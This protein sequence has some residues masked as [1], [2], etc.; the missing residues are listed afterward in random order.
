M[1]C[2]ETLKQQKCFLGSK[3]FSV[4]CVLGC[5][6]IWG[7]H[8][9]WQH[10][11]MLSVDWQIFLTSFFAALTFKIVIYI[12]KTS[13]K[14]H[15]SSSHMRTSM[16]SWM[17][18]SVLIILQV[19]LIVANSISA[20]LH[21]ILKSVNKPLK[22]IMYKLIFLDLHLVVLVKS[23]CL[24][25][26]MCFLILSARESLRYSFPSLPFVCLFA[27][28]FKICCVCWATAL[29]YQS[30][31]KGYWWAYVELNEK[32]TVLSLVCFW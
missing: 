5:L 32:L 24:S 6:P 11:W 17:I 26:S 14:L 4:F 9:C 27:D 15:S 12:R 31:Q 19:L 16:S 18:F 29:C 22:K 2:F 25:V 3:N 20:V 23:L 8:P 10:M 21:F 30:L 13:M 7:R 1:S 28:V